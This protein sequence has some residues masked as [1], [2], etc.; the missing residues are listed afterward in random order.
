MSTRVV[1]YPLLHK[2][3]IPRRRRQL[4]GALS[5]REASWK[6][7]VNHR[8]PPIELVRFKVVGSFN[9][10]LTTI[11][12]WLT[13]INGDLATKNINKPL[14]HH[15][16]SQFI[17][18]KSPFI[19]WESNV[20][21]AWKGWENHVWMLDFAAG[22]MFDE[23]GGYVSYKWL[24]TWNMTL[25]CPFSWEFSHS[26]WRTHGF[27]TTNQQKSVWFHILYLISTISYD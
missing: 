17:V 15:G 13:T 5:A 16:Q 3:T 23:T 19:V 8:H 21:G 4:S 11:N 1:Y 24:V 22:S 14:H 2:P 7:G 27:Q 6:G 18:V 20:N 26:N 10:D 9:G 12:G 25:I